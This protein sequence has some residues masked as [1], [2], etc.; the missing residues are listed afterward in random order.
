M[1]SHVFAR[2][3]SGLVREATLLDTVLFGIMNNGAATCVW[4]Y[5]STAPYLFPGLNQPLTFLIGFILSV[6]GFG[7]MWGMLGAAMPRS[8]GSYVYNSRILHPAIGTA[9]SFANAGFVMTAWIWVLAPWVADPGLSI[10]VGA[11]GLDPSIVAWAL[12]PVGMYLVATIVNILGL[13]VVLFGLR[14]FFRIQRVLIGWSLIGAI[15]AAIIITATG[16][17]TFVQVWN[18]YA[19]VYG[20]LTWDETVSAVR[21]VFEIPDTWN[22]FSTLGALLPLSWAVMYGYVISFIGGEVKSPR[23]NIFLGQVLNATVMLAI[24]AWNALAL[25]AMA[26]WDGFHVLGYIDNEGLDGYNFPFST[27]YLNIASM[28]TG[29]NPV[30]GFI[31]GMSFIFADFMWIPF[32]YIAFSRGLFAWGMDRIGPNW[33]TDIHPRWHQPVKLLLTEFILGQIGITW[34]AVSPDVLAGFSV[35]V[36]QLFSVFGFTALSSLIF[37]FRKKVRHI[38]ETSPHKE[39]KVAGIPVASISGLLTLILVGILVWAAFYSEG[40]EA[41][42]SIWT[43][44]YIVVWISG[45]L[46]Y[47]IWKWYR[48]REGIDVML[49]FKELAPE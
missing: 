4:Y 31:F 20:S 40:M 5:T 39:W 41:I 17:D 8:G 48:M 23:K 11:M 30:L 12:E 16:H 3:A 38:W 29:L 22:W 19:Q 24:T 1:S 13:L 37:P 6:F 32:S 14:F 47:Y 35:E 42:M 25:E 21:S 9:V 44:I 33:F 45:L 27:T 15:I 49:A 7:M 46:W 43:P 10:L 2:R 28:L 18:H 26:G 34:Y 36:M